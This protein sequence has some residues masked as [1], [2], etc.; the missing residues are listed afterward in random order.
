MKSADRCTPSLGLAIALAALAIA[1]CAEAPTGGARES[2]TA[3]RPAPIPIAQLLRRPGGTYSD[4]APDGAPPLD[5]DRL[6]DAVPRAEPLHQSA[7]DP[8][9][10]FGRE[11]V[12]M[13]ALAAYRRQGT[14]SWYGRK[15]HGQR[16]VSGEVYD[17][18]AMSAAHPTLPIPSFARITN[19]EN[20]RSVVVRVNDRGPFASGRMMDVS[21]AAAHRLG[22]AASGFA[23]V[24][25]ESVLP[26]D[27]AA[28]APEAAARPMPVAPA[29]AAEPA[30][31][32]QPPAAEIAAV[33]PP[34][35]PV[36][37]APQPG[38]APTLD[39]EAPVPVS[40]ERGGIFLQLGAFSVR[41]NAESFRVRMAGRL[42]AIGAPLA[43]EQREKLFRVQ[44]GPFADRAE[45]NA[46][47]R[48]VRELLE[49]RPILVVR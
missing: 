6:P 29:S 31:A 33:G 42:E 27:A 3:V 4:D 7:N 9:T 30:K 38:S 23:Q 16:T 5:L 18:Y 32:A 25:V 15:F 37:Q 49:L 10:V 28:R 40:A 39:S 1:G 24:E 35:A 11:Y 41:A 19:L 48:R 20:R 45:A 43:I 13:R 17:M 26:P 44:L 47:A 12:P 34:A 22:F 36:L 14:A 2:A 46:A 8:Y 21:Y